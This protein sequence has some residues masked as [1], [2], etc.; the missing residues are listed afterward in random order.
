MRTY[1]VLENVTGTFHH[2]MF[3]EINFAFDA[4]DIEPASEQEELVLEEHLIPAGL[5]EADGDDERRYL[6]AG[7]TEDDLEGDAD[8]EPGA[9]VDAVDT[10]GD[11]AP[12][13]PAD[14]PDPATV[15]AVLE[16]VR[17][18]GVD[19]ETVTRARD[20]LELENARNRPRRK[21]QD[22]LH[23]IL[24]DLGAETEA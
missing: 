21:A 12:E 23:Q 10:D 22:A 16:W 18:P 4:G 24:L 3:G 20:A 1:T 11:A 7:K 2:P 19:D 9:A 15:D 8:G 5:A 14:W 13:L 17:A 6:S